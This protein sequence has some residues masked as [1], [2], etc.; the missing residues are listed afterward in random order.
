MSK[1]YNEYEGIPADFLPTRADESVLFDIAM[2]VKEAIKLRHD[3][4]TAIEIA[5][6]DQGVRRLPGSVPPWESNFAQTERPDA[7][8]LAGLAAQHNRLA[9]EAKSYVA[10]IRGN[11][12]LATL[13]R[14]NLGSLFPDIGF[15][16]ST[17]QFVRRLLRRKETVLQI[18]K[19][20]ESDNHVL[21]RLMI[22]PPQNY[23]FY[24]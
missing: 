4:N 22:K 2:N 10:R 7:K 8:T 19:P 6:K 21:I 23:Q 24:W 12:K 11:S 5:D 14:Q 17:G 18:F 1:P 16:E 3:F 20:M 15:S 13:F 9:L